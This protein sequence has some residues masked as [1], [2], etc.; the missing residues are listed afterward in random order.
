M[1]I[2]EAEQLVIDAY[3]NYS[4]PDR[5]QLMEAVRFL[6]E[7]TGDPVHITHLGGLYHESGRYDLALKCFEKSADLGDTEACVCLGNMWLSGDAGSVDYNNAFE[8]FSKAL[9]AGHSYAKICIAD[10]Y[11]NG[12]YVREDY[13][14]Y[15][16]IIEELYQKVKDADWIDEPLP[17]VF[18]KMA[19]IRRKQGKIE[20]AVQ[21]LLD[22]RLALANELEYIPEA[23]V[24][25]TMEKLTDELY[26]LT[27]CDM[28]NLEL[29]DLFHVLKTPCKVSFLY[30]GKSYE[31]KSVRED[32][33]ISVVFSH[34]WY[35]SIK[36]FFAKACIGDD[37]L[38][39]LSLEIHGLGVK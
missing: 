36:E 10:M 38:A 25:E 9:E 33:G 31:V 18:G 1:T 37:K 29:F 26:E 12:Y 6:A 14:K 5:H 32:Y 11:K 23:D 7:E 17:E 35:R 20:E 2:Q 34:E 8:W 24:L 19:E 4:F 28:D 30:E 15:C 22:A 39:T 13:D 27:E 16:S 21:L 3:D